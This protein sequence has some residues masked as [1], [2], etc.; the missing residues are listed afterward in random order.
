M[1]QIV[2]YAYAYSSKKRA[3]LDPFLRYRR[4]LHFGAVI[5]LIPEFFE[6]FGNLD[7]LDGIN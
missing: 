2:K 7:F 5:D 3:I 1:P 6:L 4:L